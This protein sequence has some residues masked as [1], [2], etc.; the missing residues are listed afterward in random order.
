MIPSF[1]FCMYVYFVLEMFL[2]HYS[3]PETQRDMVED[4]FAPYT[5][6]RGNS[7]SVNDEGMSRVFVEHVFW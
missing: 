4:S 7:A 6:M 3:T 2:E 5:W 1:L